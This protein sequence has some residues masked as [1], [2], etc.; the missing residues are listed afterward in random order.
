MNINL[1][2]EI[3]KKFPSQADFADKV[4]S[5]EPIVSR[6]VRGRQKLSAK[7]QA[8]WAKALGCNVEDIFT[9]AAN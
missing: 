4:E 7:S 8:R 6:V 1:K 2:M 5:R 3:L 9:D